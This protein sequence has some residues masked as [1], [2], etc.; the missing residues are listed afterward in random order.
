MTESNSE[1]EFIEAAPS[2]AW[3]RSLLFSMMI[4]V[5]GAVIGSV[6]TAFYMKDRDVPRPSHRP[7]NMA[8]HIADDMERK[9]GLTSEQKQKV[10][11]VME[12]H[13]KK[14]AEI[15]AEVAPRIE[16]EFDEVR[17]SVETVLTPEQAQAWVPE[18]EKM[19]RKWR[20]RSA[21]GTKPQ[22]QT[23]NE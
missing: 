17:K 6:G 19:R 22:E 15:R 7:E 13:S 18:Y 5:C 1:H 3:V 21:E 8:Q 16:A 9:Y 20:P 4:L 23:R 10:L 11:S 14:L 2:R 12:E